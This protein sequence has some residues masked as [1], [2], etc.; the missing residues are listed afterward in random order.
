MEGRFFI[1]CWGAPN[2]RIYKHLSVQD[3]IRIKMICENDWPYIH[4]RTMCYLFKSCIQSSTQPLA[5]CSCTESLNSC[6][7]YLS[8]HLN[9]VLWWRIHESVHVGKRH[10]NMQT[11]FSY[12]SFLILITELCKIHCGQTRLK[13]LTLHFFVSYFC[14]L[15]V[16]LFQNKF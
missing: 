15:N 12:V 7:E 8:R 1:V 6:I 14:I 9:K 11:H 16:L 10:R 13:D 3:S 5:F 2:P 4:I